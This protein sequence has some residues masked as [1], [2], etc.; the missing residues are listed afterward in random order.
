MGL[1]TITVGA[2]VATY[3]DSAVAA[4]SKYYYRIKAFNAI[5]NSAYVKPVK[6]AILLQ[7]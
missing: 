5:G 1:A 7:Q 2:N 4:R 6:V 3:T